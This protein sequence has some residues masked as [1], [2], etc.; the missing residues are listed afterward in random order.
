MFHRKVDVQQSNLMCRLAVSSEPSAVPPDCTYQIRMGK[1]D[2]HNAL[3][4]VS[5]LT[6]ASLDIVQDF[7]MSRVALVENGLELMVSRSKSV[8][9][10]LG[11]D[12]S[13]I[14]DSASQVS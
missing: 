6:E 4:G 10:M 12:P 13:T 1:D 8:A 7:G 3:T 14:Y 9:E 5:L 11:E 2:I